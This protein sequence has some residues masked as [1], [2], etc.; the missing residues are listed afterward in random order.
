MRTC[1]L[2]DNADPVNYQRADMV[3]HS[4]KDEPLLASVNKPEFA[5]FQAFLWLEIL[6]HWPIFIVGAHGLYKGDRLCVRY[7]HCTPH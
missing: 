2:L 5:W 3:S 7:A 4:L 1:E 6:F